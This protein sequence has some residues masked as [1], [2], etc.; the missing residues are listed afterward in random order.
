MLAVVRI[1]PAGQKRV[2]GMQKTNADAPSPGG[3]PAHTLRGTCVSAIAAVA[4]VLAG[5]DQANVVAQAPAP[6]PPQVTVAKPA[7]K[8]I[9]ETDEY[10]GRFVAVDFVEVRTRVSG[11]LEKIHF[12]DGQL[13]KAGDPLLTI[14]RRPLEAARDRAQAALMQAKA[15]LTFAESDLKRGQELVRGTTITQ[16]SLDQRKQAR[17]VAEAEVK[18]QEAALRQA[19]LDLGYAELTAPISGRIGDRRV[20]EGNLVT[21]GTSGSTTLLAT[22]ASTDPIRFEFTFDEASFL[23]YQRLSTS[24]GADK[25]P[26]ALKVHLKLLDEQDFA[27][28]GRLDFIDNAIDRSSGT[29]RGRA[30]F[31]NADGV[32]TPGMFGRI[33]LP[34][35]EPADA[36]VVPDTAIGTEQVRKFVMVVDAENVAKPKFVTLGPVVDGQRVISSGLAAD[37]TI[38]VNGLIRVRPGMKVNPQFETAQ[39]ASASAQDP[40]KPQDPAARTN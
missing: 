38:V 20:S 30:E 36:L 34:A 37:D 24:G 3:R 21:G 14:D 23:R 15:S 12:K 39:P 22:I 18:S 16:Q 10:V 29:I 26:G 19:E 5:C 11:Y 35:K 1:V 2:D 33:R 31:S 40:S 32:L 9:T 25:R 7:V 6:P 28:E 27:R 13:V 4:L 8:R 17:A